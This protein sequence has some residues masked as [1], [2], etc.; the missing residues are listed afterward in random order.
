MEK[1]GTVFTEHWCWYPGPGSN[2]NPGKDFRTA[3]Y[4]NYTMMHHCHTNPFEKRTQFASQ[5]A[6]MINAWGCVE[7]LSN[8]EC[9]QML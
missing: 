8:P 3:L 6:C 2:N 1:A 9:M 5:N 4:I 7:I